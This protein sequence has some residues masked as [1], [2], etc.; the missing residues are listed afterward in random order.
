M[1]MSPV[2]FIKMSAAGNDFILV[3]ARKNDYHFTSNQISKISKRT[4]IGCDQFVVLRNSS[5]HDI[6]MDIYNQDGSQAGACG[7]ATRCVAL[8]L[9]KEVGQNQISVETVSGILLCRKM[10]DS[11]V[12][13]MGKPRLHWQEIP[14]ANAMDVNT[15]MFDGFKFSAVS[16]GNPHIVTFLENELS[17]EDFFVF[18]PKLESHHFFPQKTN[19]EFVKKI[20]SNHLKV[21]VWE[22]GVG[23]TLACGTGACAVGVAALNNNIVS[24]GEIR[25]EFKGGDIFISLND[26]G[27]VMMRGGA[28]IIFHGVIDEDFLLND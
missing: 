7:N 11:I 23:E 10:G 21:R 12:V 19:V 8:L 6:L 15:I 25:V 13:N 2:S 3:D 26:G 16:M 17:D 9:M 5:R 1:L 14:L 18:G 24:A 4:N 27:E 22:R 20:A 28:Q